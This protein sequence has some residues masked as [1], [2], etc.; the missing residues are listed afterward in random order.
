MSFIATIAP[1]AAGDDVAAM[2]RDQQQAWGYVPNYAR[3]FSHRPGVLGRWGALL[4]E[5]KRPLDPRRYE[6]VTLAAAHELGNSPCALA[7]GAR[8]RPFFTDEQIVAIAQGRVDGLLPPAEQAMLRFARLVARDAAA[9]TAEHVAELK[10]HGFSDAEV[11]DVAAVV[12]TRA[13][14]TKVLDAMGVQPNAPLADLPAALREVLVVGR[15][16]DPAPCVTMPDESEPAL[17]ARSGC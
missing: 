16:V 15:P 2:Y 12:A 1:E 11:F 9:V 14:F 4:A 8:L 10:R 6:L 7:H 17:A 13:F 3:V 5:V